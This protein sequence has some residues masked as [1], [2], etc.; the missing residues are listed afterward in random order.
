MGMPTAPMSTVLNPLVRVTLWN[1]EVVTFPNHDIPSIVRGVQQLFEQ[2]E[3]EAARCIFQ[4]I[5]GFYNPRRRHSA[6][7]WKSP[8]AFEAKA[9]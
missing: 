5:N 4:Y 7:G 6:L 1:T 8:L 9:A 3:I 2:P